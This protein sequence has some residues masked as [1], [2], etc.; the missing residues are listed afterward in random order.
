MSVRFDGRV[1][2][3]SGGARGLGFAHANLLASL[4]AAVVVNDIGSAVDGQGASGDVA[5]EAVAVLQRAGYTAVASTDS[6]TGRTGAQAVVQT[7][8]DS[9]GKVDI[10]VNNAGIA[11]QK[12]VDELTDQ[13]FEKV[14]R[15]HV[16]GSFYLTSA[17]WRGMREQ[18]YG[19]VLNTTSNVALL[20]SANHSSY[21]AAKGALFGM[22]KA[23]AVE[24]RQFGIAV[25][26]LAPIARTRMNEEAIRKGRADANPARREMLDALERTMALLDPENVAAVAAWLVHE[27]CPVTGEVFAAAGGRAGRCFVGFTPG[28]TDHGLTID[29]VQNHFDEIRSTEGFL[30]FATSAEELTYL[31]QVLPQASEA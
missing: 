1:A 25:N 18:R 8:I 15:V 11:L 24:G 2:I 12:P 30:E 31:D 29:D 23:L 26:A 27:D 6:I 20:G 3:V 22:T 16:W 19:R 4:G 17:V 14:L 28:Y 10:L 21:A 9:F 7:A 13:D 5:H